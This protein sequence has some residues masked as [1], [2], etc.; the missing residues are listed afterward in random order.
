MT[1]KEKINEIMSLF[2]VSDPTAV[3]NRA[4]RKDTEFI[5][6]LYDFAQSNKSEED[7][8]FIAALLMK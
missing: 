3:F 2:K 1:K 7:K 6:R 8:K 5:D 4:Y